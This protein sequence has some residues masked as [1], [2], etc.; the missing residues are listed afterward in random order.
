MTQGV[1]EEGPNEDGVEECESEIDDE[2]SD[3]GP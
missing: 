3:Y 1:D 2:E